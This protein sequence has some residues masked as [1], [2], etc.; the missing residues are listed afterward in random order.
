MTLIK[1]VFRVKWLHW[2]FSHRND[3][4]GQV[5]YDFL[6]V[7]LISTGASFGSDGFE[8]AGLGFAVWYPSF[9]ELGRIILII[10]P[11]QMLL[12]KKIQSNEED[13][14]PC[15]ENASPQLT[16]LKIILNL[17][18]EPRHIRK[19]QLILIRIN[20]WNKY[21]QCWIS[22]LTVLSN[23]IQVELRTKKHVSRSDSFSSV[24]IDIYLTNHWYF[25]TL[26]HDVIVE[27]LSDAK[28]F[29]RFAVQ[30]NHHFQES[31]QKLL[32]K[33]P[34]EMEA[35]QRSQDIM[36]PGGLYKRPSQ[37]GS[38]HEYG[39]TSSRSSS[40]TSKTFE[41]LR[42]GLQ[43]FTRN[44]AKQ[45]HKGD[46]DLPMSGMKFNRPP[47]TKF[48]QDIRSGKA[49]DVTQTWKQTTSKA[50]PS[51]SS[52]QASSQ[53]SAQ[54]SQTSSPPQFSR[55]E[56]EKNRLWYYG[57]YL[58]EDFKKV[59]GQKWTLFRS[60]VCDESIFQS[61][62]VICPSCPTGHLSCW[63]SSWRLYLWRCRRRAPL[64]FEEVEHKFPFLLDQNHLCRMDNF[65]FRRVSMNLMVNTL[66]IRLKF[67]EILGGG[68]AVGT[69]LLIEEDEQTCFFNYLLRYFLAEGLAI[70]HRTEFL[71]GMTASDTQQYLKRLPKNLTLEEP[72]IP[73]S[74]APGYVPP[75][76][77]QSNV[78]TLTI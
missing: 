44:S 51:G 32:G 38:T 77:D 7:S 19:D 46:G 16:I 21:S 43:G 5:D 75:Q 54:S 66:W 67:V 37:P 28:W 52:S 34:K 64:L 68:L 48:L 70:G 35:Y 13:R 27:R 72:D 1:R 8:G 4:R 69:I 71:S 2:N 65:L 24:R 33:S 78:L 53:A 10:W 59:M 9:P 15:L 14:P 47:F 26:S 41:D 45:L 20:H 76:L 60:G 6:V 63:N 22:H 29:Q 11:G 74:Q 73:T 58:A 55:F 18:K 23:W 3:H 49:P 62:S 61:L 42:D 57:K 17:E 30:S 56:L 25:R 50:S 12:E 36:K 31:L 40:E 39:S